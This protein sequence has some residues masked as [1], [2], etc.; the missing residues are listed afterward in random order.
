MELMSP[1]T[2]IIVGFDELSNVLRNKSIFAEL[3]E[4]NALPEARMVIISQPTASAHL[5]QI[6]DRKVEIFGFDQ[7]SRAD[8][9]NKPFKTLPLS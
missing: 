5:H 4:K 2:L 3:L 7:T 6:V 9:A 8:Y 1:V